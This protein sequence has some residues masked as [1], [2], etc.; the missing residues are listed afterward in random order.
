MRLG[1]RNECAAFFD[2]LVLAGN[3]TKPRLKAIYDI[4]GRGQI[5]EKKLCRLSGYRGARP[6]RIGNAVDR[7]TQLDVY[8]EVMFAACKWLQAGNP[9]G[10]EEQNLLRSIADTTR[11]IW[12]RPDNGIW[13]LRD[14]PRHYTYSKA[15]AWSALNSTIQLALNGTIRAPIEPYLQAQTEIRTEI[16]ARSKSD[17]GAG[18]SGVL[19]NPESLDVALLLLPKHGYVPYN[20]PR[21]EATWQAIRSQ[22]EEGGLL[23]RYPPAFGGNDPNEGSLIVCNLWAVEFLARSGRFEEAHDRMDRIMTLANDV[24]LYSEAVDIKTGEALGNTPQAYSHAGLIQAIMALE[25]V[26]RTDRQ[27]A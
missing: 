27:A 16:E 14:R 21:M 24:G 3:T 13:E 1:F 5:G 19:D 17:Y 7:Q 15:M 6:V 4:Y 9:T 18:Y 22:L 20:H 26:A 12:R 8:G 25:Q 11:D 10:A 2:W 23:R